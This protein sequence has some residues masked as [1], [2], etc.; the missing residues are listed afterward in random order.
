MESK[1][2]NKRIHPAWQ[3]HNRSLRSFN[4]NV[5]RWTRSLVPKLLPRHE[6]IFITAMPKSGST[7]MMEAMMRCSGYFP[8]RLSGALLQEQNLLESRILDSWS[9]DSISTTHTRATKVNL[10][11]MHAYRIRPVVLVRNIFDVSVSMRDH[12]H[13]ESIWNPTFSPD[14]AFLDMTPERQLDAVIDLAVPWN[15]FFV[16]EWQRADVDKLNLRYEDVIENP[17]DTLERILTFYGVDKP[18]M[19]PAAAWTEAADSGVTRKN[20]GRPGRGAEAFS[21]QQVQ[22]VKDLAAHFPNADFGSIGL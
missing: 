3:R 7:L 22:R 14:P 5:L 19:D 2:G 17:V 11:R 9:F 8:H 12:I 15:L 1:G 20:V 13:R 4:T 21:D 16:A 10:E 6:T 18:R